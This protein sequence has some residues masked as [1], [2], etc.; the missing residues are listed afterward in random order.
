MDETSFLVRLGAGSFATV[1]TVA[2]QANVA[3]KQVHAREQ[4]AD[5]HS[6]F[7]ILSEVQ[8]SLMEAPRPFFSIPVPV[9]HFETWDDVP[10]LDEDFRFGTVRD[11]R[12]Q[13]FRVEKVKRLNSD[14]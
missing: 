5:L 6:E 8:G 1:F 11:E 9:G 13:G 14:S 4:C 2:S 3:L 12:F 7:S 10:E